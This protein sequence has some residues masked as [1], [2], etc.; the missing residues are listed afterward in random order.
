MPTRNINLSEHLD[1][2]VNERVEARR[3]KNVNKMP[4]LQKF[5]L[6]PT[7][8]LRLRCQLIYGFGDV[9]YNSPYHP[10]IFLVAGVVL[11]CWIP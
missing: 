7:S 11:L 6:N 2:F 5:N 8:V 10:V 4:K 9:G 1:R 3:Y